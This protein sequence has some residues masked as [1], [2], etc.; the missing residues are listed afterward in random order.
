MPTTGASAAMEGA[1]PERDA[2]VVERMREAGALLLAKSNLTEFAMG[3]T[4]ISS[5]GGQTSNAY[6]QTRTPGGSSGGTGAAVAANFGLVGTGSDTGQSTR[7]PSSANNLVGFRTTRGLV[8]RGGIIPLSVTQDEIGPITRTVEDNARMLDVWAGY[9]PEDPITAFGIGKAPETYLDA[10]GA[11]A[12]DGARIGV[13]RD[14]FGSEEVH[15]PVNAVVDQAMMDME[16]LGATLI[17]IE[18]PGIDDLVSG[19]GTSGYETGPAMAAYLERFGENAPYAT[20][21]E[22]GAT[23]L[24]HP[25]IQESFDARAEREDPLSDPTYQA[26]FRKRDQL[27]LTLMQAMAENDLDALFYPHQQR[28]V[29]PIG[30]DQLDRNGVLS[31]ATGFPAITFPGGFSEPTPDAPLGVPVGIELLGPEFSEPRLYALAYAF[32]QATDYRQP[33]QFLVEADY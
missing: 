15:A 7:S 2:F 24:V 26:I 27:R 13:M 1:V 9:D 16:T 5:L 20:L 25:E 22:I 28:L 11:E 12:L 17:D 10:L 29:V 30:E 18:I 3:G 6:D 32:E 14:F 23:G 8:S 4:T 19:M 33:P 21:Q 31:N